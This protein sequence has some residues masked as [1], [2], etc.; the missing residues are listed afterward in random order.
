MGAE[1][2]EDELRWAAGTL[3]WSTFLPGRYNFH[4]GAPD[5]EFLS[6]MALGMH[7]PMLETTLAGN[8]PNHY[9]GLVVLRVRAN[10]TEFVEV[11]RHSDEGAVEHNLCGAE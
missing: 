9:Q 4:E 7:D 11:F 2:N 5:Q 6:R 3:G 8:D 1:F 10:S